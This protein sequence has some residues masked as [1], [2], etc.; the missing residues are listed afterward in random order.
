MVIAKDT[1]I[2]KD[3]PVVWNAVCESEITRALHCIECGRPVG[4]ILEHIHIA[5]KRADICVPIGVVD[6]IRRAFPD[7]ISVSCDSC[8]LKYCS[9]ECKMTGGSRH[10]WTC[11]AENVQIINKHDPNGHFHLAL[12]AIVYIIETVVTTNQYN[13][14]EEATNAFMRNFHSESFIRSLHAVRQ[15]HLRFDEESFEE[16]VHPS[17]FSA[18][19]G[20][21]FVLVCDVIQTGVTIRGLQIEDFRYVLTERFFDRLLGTF[22][23]NNLSILI[24]S[25]LNDLK[26]LTQKSERLADISEEDKMIVLEFLQT[27]VLTANSMSAADLTGTGLFPLYSKMNHSC[28]GCNTKNS[29]GAADTANVEV[30]AS[31]DIG[32]GDEI[33]SSYLHGQGEGVDAGPHLHYRNRRKQLLQYLFYCSCVLCTEQRVTYDSEA[34]EDEDEDNDEGDA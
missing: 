34:S 32:S 23:V 27:F 15:G 14:V 6:A 12:K 11:G 5:A 21:I 31:R 28:C 25:P 4:S 20:D 19:L 1:L 22:R 9:E 3:I 33:L 7:L 29:L 18:Y 8:P 10:S 17:Y 26:S 2:F 16:F 13:T 24:K 30:Y